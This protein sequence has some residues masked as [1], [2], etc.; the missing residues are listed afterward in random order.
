VKSVILEQS[1]N[2]INKD[3]KKAINFFYLNRKFKFE[4]LMNKIL[5]FNN[6]LDR[7]DESVY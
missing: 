2:N 4:I 6:S 5:V 7:K 3:K 1:E